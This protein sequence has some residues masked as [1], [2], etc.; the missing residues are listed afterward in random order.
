MTTKKQTKL[1]IDQ[2]YAWIVVRDTPN[3]FSIIYETEG[4]FR[5]FGE[6]VC[7]SDDFVESFNH[8]E[9]SHD[10]INCNADLIILSV[11]FG[12]D[13]EET[14]PNIIDIPDYDSFVSELDSYIALYEKAKAL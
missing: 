4:R 10:I 6:L 9:L 7:L 12:V 8:T 11:M 13:I 2:D 3:V 14:I 1:Y 5:I